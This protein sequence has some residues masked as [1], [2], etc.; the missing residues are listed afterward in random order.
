MIFANPLFLFGL[1]VVP[2]LAFLIIYHRVKPGSGT[3]HYSDIRILAAITPGLKVRLA[4]GLPWLS[5]LAL[6]LMIVALARPQMGLE[7]SRIRH[8]GVDV[9]LAIDVS[10]SMGARDFTLSGRQANRLDAVKLVARNF[11]KN[12]PNDRIGIVVFS[13]RPYILAPL[14]WDHDWA[15]SRLSEIKPGTVEESGTAIGAALATSINRLQDSTAKSRVI[16]LLTDGMNNSGLVAP[17]TAAASARK[18]GMSLYTIGAGSRGVAPVPV[19]GTNGHVTYQNQA[20]NIDETLLTQLAESTGGRYFRATD[21][22][23]LSVIFE[24]INR[25][26]KTSMEAP[27]F[28][29]YLELYPYFLVAA[30]LLLC[31]ES[32]LANT[33]FRRLP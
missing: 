16:I 18:A 9:I 26:A 11:I 10:S 4:N 5:L 33:V 30:L 24:R 25:M 1:L 8:A 14:S 2:P 29:D 3:I 15:I 6:V 17:E 27:K 20:V 31:G 22:R 23:S 13:G 12:R 21:T 28:N 32:L 7:Q 19:I